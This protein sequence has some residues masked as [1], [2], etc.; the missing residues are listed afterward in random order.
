MADKFAEWDRFARH[1]SLVEDPH[2]ALRWTRHESW[3]GK[4]RLKALKRLADRLA[5]RS[6]LSTLGKA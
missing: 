2:K 4:R 3:A 6:V 5:M 1:L